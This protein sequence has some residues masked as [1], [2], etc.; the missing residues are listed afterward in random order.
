M[1]DDEL[2]MDIDSEDE[3]VD[4]GPSDGRNGNLV[5]HSQAERRAHHNALERKRRDHIK[6][7]FS[8]LRDVVPSLK[9]EK[10]SRAQILKKA[11]EFIA[12]MRASNA[13]H[14]SDIEDLKRQNAELELQITA[15]EKM[16]A[17]RNRM[18]A[19]EA[20][21]GKHSGSTA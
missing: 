18:E 1:S 16:K 5:F 20:L 9:G 15:M 10:S 13:T 11:S 2:E 3:S 21:R 12:F 7:S 17:E 4:G 8:G 6:D 19:R 14:Q